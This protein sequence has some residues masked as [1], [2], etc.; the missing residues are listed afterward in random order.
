[1]DISNVHDQMK[2][3]GYGS[4]AAAAAPDQPIEE[5]LGLRTGPWTAEED[6]ILI[7]YVNLHGEG[8]W[9]SLARHAGT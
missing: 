5:G 2:S 3:A 8:R 9:N 6:S 1:M 4:L 7:D